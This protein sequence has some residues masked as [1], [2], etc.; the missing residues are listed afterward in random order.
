MDIMESI[1]FILFIKGDIMMFGKRREP[2]GFFSL[3]QSPLKNAIHSSSVHRN[4]GFGRV[5]FL[6]SELNGLM[7]WVCDQTVWII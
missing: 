1:I 4:T 7:V 5:N 2:V 6:H 3:N